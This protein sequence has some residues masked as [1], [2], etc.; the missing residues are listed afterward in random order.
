MLAAR[1]IGRGYSGLQKFC[2]LMDLP[3][4]VTKSNFTRHQRALAK[5][6]HEVAEK[7]EMLQPSNYLRLRKRV[8]LL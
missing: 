1:R 3:K 7:V 6:A 2:T 8:R 5:A 4:P